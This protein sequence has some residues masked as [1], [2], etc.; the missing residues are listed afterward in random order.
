MLYGTSQRGCQ[1]HSVYAVRICPL[2]NTKGP[3]CAIGARILTGYVATLGYVVDTLTD[4][5][6]WPLSAVTGVSRMVRTAPWRSVL[7][8]GFRVHSGIAAAVMDICEG[9]HQTWCGWF[10]NQADRVGH[11]D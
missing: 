1:A 8:D 6:F 11:S 7:V 5:P 2:H 3:P 9:L 4:A 10:G